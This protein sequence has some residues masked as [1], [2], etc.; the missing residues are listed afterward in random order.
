[1]CELHGRDVLIILYIEHILLISAPP[2]FMLCI[3]CINMFIVPERREGEPYR[4]IIIIEQTWPIIPSSVAEVL[5][6]R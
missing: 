1:M 2:P 3:S 5:C 4:N 6:W